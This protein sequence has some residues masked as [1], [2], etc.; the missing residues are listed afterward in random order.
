MKYNF[1]IILFLFCVL[2]TNTN[3]EKSPLKTYDG[4]KL[5]YFSHSNIDSV[6]I[7][8][9]D[10]E[11]GQEF[12]TLDYKVLV[13]MFGEQFDTD[14][15]YHVKIYED[16]SSGSNSE[17][18]YELEKQLYFPANSSLDTLNIRFFQTKELEFQTKYLTIELVSDNQFKNNLL[19]QN[20][21][22]SVGS[23][24]KFSV[25]SKLP[26]PFGWD[27]NNNFLGKFSNKKFFLI[28]KLYPYWDFKTLYAS[29][30]WGTNYEYFG[31]LLH[32]H[33]VSQAGKGS[34]VLE[35]DGSLMKAG[36]FFN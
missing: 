27:D 33:L 25:S 9:V 34:P 36:S 3:C 11:T 19:L 17:K 35:N 4:E 20:K 22:K 15:A 24:I 7:S 30:A 1:V 14:M 31:R 18:Y 23:K 8:L 10:V 12:D 16:D 13:G 21:S 29:V 2:F 5:L 6:H 32:G 28:N 26:N